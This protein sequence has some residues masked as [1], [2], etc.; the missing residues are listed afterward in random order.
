MLVGGPGDDLLDGGTG[1][2]VVRGGAGIDAAT[3]EDRIDE[4]DVRLDGEALDGAA[5]EF[6]NVGP[7][8]DVEDVVGGDG[9]DVLIGNAQSNEL[10]GGP[11]DDLLDGGTG[12]DAL[13]GGEDDDTA[14][15][16]GRTDPLVVDLGQ[17]GP[18][19]GGSGDDG[20]GPGRD[21]LDSIENAV[22]G[23]GSDTLIGDDTDNFLDGGPGA[24]SITGRGG[25][26]VV[27]YD[28]RAEGVS[29]Q[30][31]A[32][33]VSGSPLDGPPGARDA[34]GIDVEG[35]VGGAGADRLVGS[36][37][38]NFLA[39]VEGDDVLD[40]RGPGDDEASCGAGTDGYYADSED[41]VDPDCE[42]NL[43]PAPRPRR[44]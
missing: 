41:I 9:S 37:A 3:Y 43:T 30:L 22:T 38:D 40:L 2:D 1:D 24:D 36:A 42:Q 29:V 8:G 31:A 7:E 25:F 21:R 28:L 39:G 10:D 26:D 14:D 6:D 32:G 35:V 12:P 4:V 13:L 44:R 27:F 16:F 33:A 5:D 17:A 18:V 15:W 19:A 20:P 34:L 11:G 23:S